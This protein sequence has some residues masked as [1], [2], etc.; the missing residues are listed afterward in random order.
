MPIGD[1]VRIEHL[2]I[3]SG[4]IFILAL[5]FYLFFV[6][7]G[8]LESYGGDRKSSHGGWLVFNLFLCLGLG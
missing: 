1:V 8:W 7:I 6:S 2:A 5:L 4:E 3:A